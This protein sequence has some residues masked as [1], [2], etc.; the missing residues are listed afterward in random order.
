MPIAFKVNQIII[1]A[2]I[3]HNLFIGAAEKSNKHGEGDRAQNLIAVIRDRMKVQERNK[4]EIFKRIGESFG[5]DEKVQQ[6][7][8]EQITQIKI[9][10]WKLNFHKMRSMKSLSGMMLEF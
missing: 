6:E 1:L 10:G 5:V 4:P 9:F 7:V 3:P 2:Q 8:D